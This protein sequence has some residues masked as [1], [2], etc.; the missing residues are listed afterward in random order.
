MG[1][2]MRKPN[3]SI[4]ENKDTDQLCGYSTA[5][6]RLCFSYINSTISPLPKSE[7]SS[8]QLSSEDVEPGLCWTWL[9]TQKAGFLATGLE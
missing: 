4:C 7:I 2:V 1:Q 9:E 5:D 8:P 3:F 6:Q